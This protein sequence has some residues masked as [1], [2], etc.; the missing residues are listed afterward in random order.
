MAWTSQFQQYSV[1]RIRQPRLEEPLESYSASDLERWV[2]LR[3]SADVG[4][5]SE[6]VKFTRSRWIQRKGIGGTCIIP[7]GRWLLVGDA[8]HSAVTVYDL[9][10]PNLTER[11][12]ILPDVQHKQ[13][14]D[15]MAIEIDPGER[16]P[17]L[18]FTLALSPAVHHGN[19]T[20]LELND[21]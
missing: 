13:R 8:N 7:G 1:E 3:R 9:D 17:Y 6:A 21:N 2:L 4:W 12:L 16:F 15:R 18:T 5:K 10:A 14:T 19:P 20:L 11:P